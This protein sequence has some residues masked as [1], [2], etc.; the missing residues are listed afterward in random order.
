MPLCQRG[1]GARLVFQFCGRH[2]QRIPVVSEPK[3]TFASNAKVQREPPQQLR[4][5]LV[6]GRRCSWGRR[7][8]KRPCCQL[9]ENAI[10]S[11]QNFRER[12][13][14]LGAVSPIFSIVAC[15]SPALCSVSSVAL[16]VISADQ[17]FSE[18]SIPIPFSSLGSHLQIILYKVEF[19]SKAT[20]K[21]RKR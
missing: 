13:P 1:E 7:V 6:K 12:V 2:C 11:C 18:H 21:S 8:P 9:S 16:V 17:N 14:E 10:R 4:S 15:S 3:L 19:F 5:C 20:S